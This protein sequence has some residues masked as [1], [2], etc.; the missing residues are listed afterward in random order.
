MKKTILFHF[1][2]AASVATTAQTYR[3]ILQSNYTSGIVYL[4]HYL[5]SS[6]NVD[7]SAAVNNKGVAIFEGNKKLPSGIY[8]IVFP[9][10]KLTADFLIGEEQVL[11]IVADSNNILQMKVTGSKEHDLFF[12]YQQFVAIKG[13]QLNDE[14]Q[15][16][17]KAT[18]A[19][20]STLHEQKYI[21]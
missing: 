10:K 11:N 14:R 19:A 17:M 9:G 8:A 3:V 6:L 12:E 2:L 15:A 7:D 21:Q 16:Y 5:G 18:T 20:D 13:K 1:L 4:T